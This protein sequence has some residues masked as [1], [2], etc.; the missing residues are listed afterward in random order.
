[1]NVQQNSYSRAKADGTLDLLGDAGVF[2]G[3]CSDGEAFRG[4]V[5]PI[6]RKKRHRCVL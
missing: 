1:M 2:R 3:I 6:R 4:R 5:L